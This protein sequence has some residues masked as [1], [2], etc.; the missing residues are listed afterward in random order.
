MGLAWGSNGAEWGRMGLASGWHR[1]GIG[2]ASGSHGAAWGSHGVS[3][4]L[5]SGWHRVSIGLA[6]GWHR[7]SIG[8][9]WAESGRMGINLQDPW[10]APRHGRLAAGGGWTPQQ[11]PQLA[12]GAGAGAAAPSEAA[13]GCRM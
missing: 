8:L 5:A 3:I 9:A 11:K 13:G 12:R 6:S 7:V 2:L 10:W 1:V 4:G